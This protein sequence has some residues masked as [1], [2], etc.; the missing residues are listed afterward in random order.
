[1][2]RTEPIDLAFFDSAPAVYEDQWDINVPAAQFWPDLVD[3]PLHWCRGL[4]IRWTS[5]R[6][7]GV[8]TTRHV[9]VLGVLQ[10]DEHFFLWEEGVR[11]AFHFTHA[12]IPLYRRLGEY[13]E[14]KPTGPNSC[15]FIWKIAVEPTLLGKAGSVGNSMLC[16][17]FFRD[18]T[19]YVKSL[20]PS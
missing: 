9:G 17:G 20:G 5:P 14:L 2:P 8:G 13:Y 7:F 11:F 6:P 15:Q 18:T 19:K 3:N 4:K 10:A 1:M 16:K 12:N